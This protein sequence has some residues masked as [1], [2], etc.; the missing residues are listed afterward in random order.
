MGDF[1]NEWKGKTG[2][3]KRAIDSVGK[4][5]EVL[6]K[7]VPEEEIV[8]VYV[9]GS[10][11]R[12]EMNEKSDVDI[13]AVVKH[14]KYIG[15]IRKLQEEKGGTYKPSELLAHSLGEFKD[16]ERHF[17][18]SSQKPKPDIFL[19]YLGNAKLIY[20]KLV[21]PKDFTLRS[22]KEMLESSVN[23]FREEFIPL[24]NERKFGF[25]QL[26]KNVFWLVDLEQRIRGKVPPGTWEKLEKSVGGKNHIIHET[27]R[28][29]LHPTK[30][31]EIRKKYLEKLS[32]YL[33]RLQ[34]KL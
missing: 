30:D 2:L 27:L 23:M 3:E 17:S 1:W 22:D 15:R 29:R 34:K 21:E 25:S 8:A 5:R 7:N 24:Y 33:D 12:R 20:G 19:R 14:D 31:S 9:K 18:Y 10:F 4:A 32:D 28:L 26:V 11:V 13:V 6:L 16:N